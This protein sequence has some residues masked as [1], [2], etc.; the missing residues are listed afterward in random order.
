MLRVIRGWWVPISF[1]LIYLPGLIYALTHHL[2]FPSNNL[3]TLITCWFNPVEDWQSYTNLKTGIAL[4]FIFPLVLF[5]FAT[6]YLSVV[7]NSVKDYVSI[8][9][10]YVNGIFAT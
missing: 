8:G 4:D 10:V 6:I 3:F 9:S 7:R 2:Y 1:L 5:L